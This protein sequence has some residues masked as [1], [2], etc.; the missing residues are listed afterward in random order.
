M[1]H[2][3]VLGAGLGGVIMAYEMKDLAGPGDKITV[4]NLGTTYSF[5]PSNPWVAVG[6]R[7]RQDITVD[8]T[9]IFATRG[10]SLKPEGAK[11]VH[12]EQ[13][14]VELNDGTF[15]AYD[16]LILA[17]GPDLAFDEVPGLGPSGYTHSV[18]HVD[19]AVDAKQA[20]DA[21]VADPGPVVVGAAQGASC[22][23][24]AYEFAFILDAALRQAK[25]RDRVPMTFVTPEPYIGHL[26]LDGVG[27]TK[28]LLE[29][30]MREHHIKWITNA[31]VAKVEPGRMFVE[32]VNEDGSL[33]TAHELPFAFSMMLPAFRGVLA[34]R[35]IENLTNPRGFVM[36]DKHQRNPAYP[37]IFAIGV[38]VAIP[39]VGKTPLPV[40]VP[41]TG[42]MIES[43]ATATAKNISALLHGQEPQ[44]V[45]S[46]NA[47]CLADF[48]DGG[49]AFVAQPQIP[50]RNV[51]WSAQ[52]KWVHA[53]K[54]GFER[55]F[56]HKIRTG[57]SET[58]YEN[59]AL[60]LLGIKKLKDVQIDTAE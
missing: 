55:Y 60:D 33:K 44:A 40:G 7:E 16:Y 51:N 30:A 47:V 29:S 3:V 10:I 37:N 41:K 1:S 43:M 39:P 59:M 6:W 34:V 38:G 27:D 24:P 32:E 57:K 9:N 11:R 52:G 28:G 12:P 48:G 4:V 20:F 31:R 5:V 50:P 2:I 13:N 25:K 56:L 23:G 46:W 26:G 18:C 42:F 54:I 53:A 22:F 19:H 49:I 14:Q 45:A 21:L 36:I 35:G 58:F 15:L 17:T 8:L